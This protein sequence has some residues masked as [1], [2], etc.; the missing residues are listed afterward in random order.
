MDFGSISNIKS[1]FS[2]K[3]E[4]RFDFGIN[5]DLMTEYDA[6]VPRNI[7]AIFDSFSILKIGMTLKEYRDATIITGLHLSFDDDVVDISIS[8]KGVVND[9]LI[10]GKSYKF[11][12]RNSQLKID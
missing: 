1:T 7:R 12:E 11:V 9:I 4:I 2:D 10:N 8:E 6:F 5:L 3:D